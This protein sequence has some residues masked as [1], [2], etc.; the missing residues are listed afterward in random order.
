MIKVQKLFWEGREMKEGFVKRAQSSI[1]LI[2]ATVMV[3]MMV[4]NRKVPMAIST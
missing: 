3:L 1:A 2:I 4:M